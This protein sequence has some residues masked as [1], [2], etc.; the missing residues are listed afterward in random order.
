MCIP[1]LGPTSHTRS[2]IL[3]VLLSVPG[4]SSFKKML[5]SITMEKVSKI[6]SMRLSALNAEISIRESLIKD[7][8]SNLTLAIKSIQ[9]ISMLEIS[10]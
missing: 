5:I 3:L 9:G 4:F 6:Y 1:H 7:Q 10:Y 8:G 2:C